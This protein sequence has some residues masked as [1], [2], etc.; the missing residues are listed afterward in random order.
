VIRSLRAGLS[1]TDRALYVSYAVRCKIN[2]CYSLLSAYP[3]WPALDL[4]KTIYHLPHR[5]LV[6]QRDSVGHAAVGVDAFVVAQDS[7]LATHRLTRSS[8]RYSSGCVWRCRLRGNMRPYACRSHSRSVRCAYYC[9]RRRTG[10]CSLWCVRWRPVRRT[11]RRRISAVCSA[12]LHI[13]LQA[14]TI[15]YSALEALNVRAT[16]SVRLIR[17]CRQTDFEGMRLAGS[18]GVL[19]PVIQYLVLDI[20]IDL[21]IACDTDK[22][23]A[24]SGVVAECS[25][26]ALSHHRQILRQDHLVYAIARCR[27][28]RRNACTGHGHMCTGARRG[29]RRLRC[30]TWSPGRYGGTSRSDYV[31]ARGL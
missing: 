24:G 25:T 7:E 15:T 21:L 17:A 12:A 22:V 6:L 13:I 18:E 1:Y 11:S 4:D 3:V 29:C 5:G 2:R 16:E 19:F 14:R 8:R 20:V 23:A 27:S 10:R 28:A 9:A 26:Y 30:G 31:C